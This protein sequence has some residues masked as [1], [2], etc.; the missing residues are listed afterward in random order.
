MTVTTLAEDRFARPIQA[1]GWG[2]VENLAFTS[3]ASA[4]S[5]ALASETTVVRLCADVDVWVLFGAA[6]V[7]AAATSVRLPA[8][9]IEYVR[10]PPGIVAKVAALGVAAS[11]TLS[12][13]QCNV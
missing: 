1:L 9:A 13:V 2:T 7:A 4:P 3:G 8:G 10:V 11:G 6:P 5:A 12:I